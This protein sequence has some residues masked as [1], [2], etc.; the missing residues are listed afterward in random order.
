MYKKRVQSIQENVREYIAGVTGP[1][2]GTETSEIGR[3]L[4]HLTRDKK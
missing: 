3:W 1:M 2:P 4:L